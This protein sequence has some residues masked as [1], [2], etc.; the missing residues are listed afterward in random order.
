[1]LQRRADLNSS[2]Y[3]H[4]ANIQGQPNLQ[5][6]P[7]IQGQPNMQYSSTIQA[8]PNMIV[9]NP[10]PSYANMYPSI[11]I[12][13]QQLSH[14]PPNQMAP[15]VKAPMLSSQVDINNYSLSDYSI[16]SEE[17]EM[18]NND[19]ATDKHPWQNVKNKRKRHKRYNETNAN[20]E[21]TSTFN[22]H[23]L[24]EK[25]NNKNEDNAETTA[26]SKQQLKE[27]SP[28]AIYIYGVTDFKAMTETL[29]QIVAD[30]QYHTRTENTVKIIL[31][32]V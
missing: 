14:R 19:M 6:S 13:G 24:L 1:M 16:T 2:M 9:N 7:S 15:P 4:H 8:E 3:Y 5:Y 23:Q 11:N 30:E 29:S 27:P 31:K 17:E 21:E 22:R 20:T 26:K 18:Q 10:T 32:T 12:Q 25:L 28:P